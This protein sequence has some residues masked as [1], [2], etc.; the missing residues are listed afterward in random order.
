VTPLP[1]AA[2]ARAG[3]KA[4]VFAELAKLRRQRPTWI[5]AG[6]VYLLLGLVLFALTQDP[7]VASTIGQRPLTALEQMLPSVQFVFSAGVGLIMLTTGSRLVGIEYSLGTI[8]IIVGRGTGRAQ[9]VLAKLLATLLTGAGLLLGYCLLASLGLSLI[10]LHF[11]G[12]LAPMGRLPMVGWRDL[13]LAVASCAISA[14]ACAAVG[15]G[16]AA[17]TRS[18]TAGI[19]LSILFFPLDNALALAFRGLFQLNH[20]HLWQA[21]S[22]ALLGPT[23]NRLPEVLAGQGA[24]VSQA[25]PQPLLQLPQLAALGVVAAWTVGLLALALLTSVRGDILD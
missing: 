15:V 11:T 6:A 12:S 9:L 24:A 10:A 1:D 4:A 8:R 16:L 19:V 3:L 25:L 13:V 23:L 5:L 7:L 14:T 22:A 20:L 21:L 17:A 2:P 18:L